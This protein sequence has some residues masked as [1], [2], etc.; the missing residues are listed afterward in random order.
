[1]LRNR[2]FVTIS[3]DLHAMLVDISRETSMPLTS[4]AEFGCYLLVREFERSRR[5]MVGPARVQVS[6]AAQVGEDHPQ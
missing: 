4:L 2:K 5:G 1:M 3:P 6:G